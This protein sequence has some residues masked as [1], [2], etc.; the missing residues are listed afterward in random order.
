MGVVKPP[1][2]LD[3]GK[4]HFSSPD[5]S[6]EVMADWEEE[7]RELFGARVWEESIRPLLWK[8]E[9]LGIYY[10]DPKPGNINLGQRQ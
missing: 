1:Y 4:A 2:L 6:P 3:F 9:S 8:L 7:R 5:F 10:L